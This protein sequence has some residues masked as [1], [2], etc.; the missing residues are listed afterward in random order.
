MEMFSKN[1]LNNFKYF[2]FTVILMMP[3]SILVHIALGMNILDYFE[4]TFMQC[5]FGGL[6][7]VLYYSA[8][9]LNELKEAKTEPETEIIN[10]NK[11]NFNTENVHRC[12]ECSCN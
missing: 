1:Q 9:K 2:S 3:S 4:A 11:L 7:F 12:G 6:A 8:Y 5:M 10:E